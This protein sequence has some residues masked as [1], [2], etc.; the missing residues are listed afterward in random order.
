[1]IKPYWYQSDCLTAITR[2]RRQ[3]RTKILF[4]MASG[5][6][7]TVTVA[8]DALQ[9]REANPDARF[10]YLCHQNE[11]L[12]QARSTFE[13]IHG[14]QHSFGF[15]NGF[16]KT[17]HQTQFLFASLQTMR[18]HHSFFRPD[19]FDYIVVDESHHTYADTYLDVVTYWQ[20]KTM[21][22]MTATP[23]RTDGQDIRR[24]FGKE[25]FFL[26]IDEALAQNLLTPV[27][28]RLLSDEIELKQLLEMPERRL[29]LKKLNRSIFVPKR[30]EEIARIIKGHAD[31]FEN[32]RIIIFCK[33]VL[34]CDHLA[35]YLKGSMPFHSRIPVHERMIR[36]EMFRTGMVRALITR[37]VFNEG[38]DI[39]QAN[40]L[41]F[42]RSTNSATVFLQQLGRGLRKSD[43]KDKVIVL[44]FVGNC[45]RIKMVINLWEAVEKKRKMLLERASQTASRQTVAY[46]EPL[47][48]N[49]NSVEFKEKILNVLDIIGKRD[50][51]ATYDEASKA[52]QALG[53]DGGR[54]MYRKRYV[55]DPRLP[56]SPESVYKSSWVS[57]RKF[58]N[59]GCYETLEEARKSALSLGFKS[60]TDYRK[61]RA[62]DP[63]LP[64]NPALAYPEEWK[65]KG[66]GYFLNTGR[67]QVSNPYSTWQ[68]A[69]KAA[70]GLGIQ[71][72]K[73]Y[74]N[75]VYKTD[76][77][78]P[79]DPL[80]I[81]KDWPG[82]GTFLGTG[83]K[84][85]EGKDKYQTWQ[86]AAKASRKMKIKS[87]VHYT[88]VYKTDSRLPANPREF[89]EDC[90]KWDVFLGKKSS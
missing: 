57:W 16:E 67:K 90:P 56:S 5:L 72:S 68:E 53:I 11:I 38:V 40:V 77:R 19:E 7:K 84:K 22:G 70:Q 49:V 73:D 36:L 30:D 61:N 32:P 10:L 81:Y 47:M 43:G 35:K 8:F 20:P 55:S 9:F 42:L 83:R 37:D 71:S 6:G 80:D 86:R 15:Y 76:P 13:A 64:G 24:V 85:S 27:D 89:Y 26:P 63:K 62:K 58:L 23:D 18:R 39:P 66:W 79:S 2:A 34:H 54:D 12:A 74:K 4:T 69:G 28:Y 60:S 31:K 41:V 52:A 88:R 75:G 3:G 65:G 44:D 1:M 87:S 21:L 46:H 51:Y 17:A 45:E 25:V 14:S 33:S 48:L 82:W 78:L 29:S 59:N 50:F